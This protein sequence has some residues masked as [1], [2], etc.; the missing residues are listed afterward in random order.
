MS[1]KKQAESPLISQFYQIKAQY[2]DSLLLYR[3]GDFYETF[4]EDA[5]AASKA[6]GIVLTKRASGN[7]TYTPL[8]GVPHHAIDSYLPKLVQAGYKVAV[9]DQLED[10]KLT[11][12]LVK[13]GVTELV[14]PGVAYNDNILSQKENNYLAAVCFESNC[15]NG[16]PSAGIAFLDIST[17]TFEVAEG[18]LEYI[19]VLLSDLQPKEIL[20]E[21]TYVDGF[22]DRFNVKALITRMDEW[23][24]VYDSCHTKLLRQLGTD[25]LK[26]FG[27]E[28]MN[29]AVSAA[30]A[31][32]FYLEMTHHTDLGHIRS[33]SR[34]DEGEFVWMDRF[35]VRNLE[36]FNSLAGAEGVS[37]LQVIDK[38]CSPMG[39]RLLRSW[40]AMPLKDVDAINARYDVIS[41]LLG[42]D[43]KLDGIRAAIGDIGDME[44]IISKAAA[45]RL[46]PREALQL[47]RGL[48]SIRNVKGMLTGKVLKTFADRLDIC[49]ELY[50]RI[51]RTILPEAAAQIGK[52]DVIASGVSD[53]LDGLRDVLSH[54]KDILLQIQQREKDATGIPS[55]R[56]SYN[57]VFGYFLEVRNIHKDK[58]P[59][60]WIRKQTLVNA[61]RYITPELKEYEEK[62]LGA[63]EKI[64]RIEAE[65]YAALVEDIRS[66]ISVL[67]ANARAVSELDCLAGFA[68]LA[69]ENN[70]CRP[71]VNDSLK[72][73]IKDGRHPVIETL[74][75]PGE[76]YV[77]NDLYLNN[78]DQQ[79]MI[80]TGPNMAGKSAFLRQT[81]LIVL[82]A[83][84]GCFVPAREA[85]IGIVDK[86]FTRVGASDNISR[87]E[88]TFMVEMLETATILNNLSE[89]SLV[90][91]DEIGRGTS[92]F[93]GMSIAWS[94]VEYLHGTHSSASKAEPHPKALFATH[95]HELN[96]LEEKYQRVHNW[97]IA[98]KETDGKV[99]FLRKLCEGGVAHSFGIHVARL[100]GMPS[101]V[102]VGAERKLR[103]LEATREDNGT[104][105]PKKKQQPMQLS[106]YQLDD[107]LLLEIKDQL[108]N[109]DINSMSPLDAFDL[110][111]E[112]KKK[113]GL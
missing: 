66:R 88:S 12:K 27:C 59:Q 52:G 28:G 93:D 41:A 48:N 46:S 79:I 29:L 34:L 32:L 108:K 51:E 72:I 67:Q 95:Y 6:L 96:E 8:A 74:M 22:R 63:E 26:G 109:A 80:L 113:A 85:K 20:V 75:N 61:E 54:G 70:Y 11:K 36:V 97:H 62:I 68:F 112:L 9:C 110:I 47:A 107:P 104:G 102:V 60:E 81:A 50:S 76:E 45:G 4:G 55:L 35:T 78:A 43:E 91:L 64:L 94:I 19:D 1:E 103:E 37:L 17:G 57:N 77:P 3:V 84:V 13:R 31:A 98:V 30:G 24:F 65:I 49:D 100:A 101:N 99:I 83:Q 2:P 89:R 105:A 25:S 71:A 33:L 5:I 69:R 18:S 44:R 53:E 7:G 15:K 73:Q 58:V 10:P 14:T 106:L 111:R 16:A 87:G 40:L 92:T 56:I 23:A 86:I 38:C 39:A 21:S 82:L 42:N 90:L